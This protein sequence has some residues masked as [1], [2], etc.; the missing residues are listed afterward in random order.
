[1]KFVLLTNFNGLYSMIVDPAAHLGLTSGT[2]S[3]W[4][5]Y[6]S[7]Y[8]SYLG[9]TQAASFNSPTAALSAYGSAVGGANTTGGEVGAASTG[10]PSSGHLL[11][12]HGSTPN[13]IPTGKK[14]LLAFT[15]HY[16]ATENS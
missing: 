13:Q 14:V 5:S 6:N 11:T 4:G 12:D 7:S 15:K 16:W 1:M 2:D 8:A 10:T 3:H 9:Q